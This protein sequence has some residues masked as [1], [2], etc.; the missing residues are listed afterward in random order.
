MTHRLAVVLT[1][2]LLL[3]LLVAFVAWPLVRILQASLTAHDGALTLGHYGAFF[4]TSATLRLLV[5]SLALAVTTSV[6][7]VGLAAV[8]AY[9]VTRTALPGRRFVAGI[10]VLTLFAPPFLVSLALV[11]VV[12]WLGL[13]SVIGGFA[14][15]VVAQVLTFLPHACLLVAAVLATIDGTLEDAAENLGARE[16]AILGRV[17]LPLARPGLLSAALAVFVMSL[18][19]FANPALVGGRYAVLATE[20]FYRAMGRDVP[21]A[22]VMGV[23]LLAPCVAAYLLNACWRGARCRIAVPAP[24]R[25]A[26]RPVGRVL[27]WGFALVA[28]TLALALTA[29]YVTVVLGSVVTAWGSDW[30]PSAA[31]YVGSGAAGRALALQRSLAVGALAAV[32]GTF[33]ALTSAYV[34]ERMRPPGRRILLAASVLPVAL[35]GTVVGLGYLLAFRWPLIVLVGTLWPLTA[36]I[37]FW[38]LPVAVLA[39]AAALRRVAPGTEET[40]VSLGAGAVRTLVRV[41]LPLLGPVALAI[42]AYFFIEGIV[43]L[44][45]ALFLVSRESGVGSVEVLL[46]V[47]AG[48]LGAACALTTLMI[49]IVA[50]VGLALRGAIARGRVA[51]LEGLTMKPGSGGRGN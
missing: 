13:E 12:P 41:T 46:Q 8:L 1:T 11:L 51:L 39:A 6:I 28:W 31:H 36:S 49:A 21:A 33:V 37:V 9:A 29:V 15:L 30:S 40:A 26:R 38:K 20:I 7:T 34:I 50:A 35:P 42:G 32:L 47:D 2:L 4:T 25:G 27:R 17:I 23:V 43:T 18:T 48:R 45:P 10:T 3:G 5:Q 44:S 22:S 24:A 16:L 14:R 19:D